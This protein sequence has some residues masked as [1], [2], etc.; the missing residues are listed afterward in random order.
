MLRKIDVNRL[1]ETLHI[2]LQ[3]IYLNKCNSI[4]KGRTINN[5]G[6]T[7]ASLLSF[8]LNLLEAYILKN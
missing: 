3:D 6:Y 4:I 8:T 1:I 2:T 5:I 7:L